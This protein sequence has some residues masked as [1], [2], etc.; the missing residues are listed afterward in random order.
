MGFSKNYDSCLYFKDIKK[1]IT[2]G[3]QCVMF[4]ILEVVIHIVNVWIANVL[5]DYNHNVMYRYTPPSYSNTVWVLV[6]LKLEMDCMIL[7]NYIH[8]CFSLPDLSHELW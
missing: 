4:F 3:V 8:L 5:L 6:N 2:L 7:F 1:R